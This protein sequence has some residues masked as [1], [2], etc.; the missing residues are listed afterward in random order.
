MSGKV[1]N[2]LSHRGPVIVILY[3]EKRGKKEIVEYAIPEDT[4]DFSFLVAEGAYY[5][6]A[7]EDKNKNFKYDKEEFFGYFGQPDQIIVPVNE[8]A[9]SESKERPDLEIQPSE[10]CY[11][12][13]LFLIA[14]F[15][16]PAFLLI[17]TMPTR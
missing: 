6:A 5:L 12:R 1:I 9:L 4:G 7:F 10:N 13:R 15:L 8:S 2:D 11:W 17:L 14:E 3:S 16:D